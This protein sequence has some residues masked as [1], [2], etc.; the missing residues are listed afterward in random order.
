MTTKE[1]V[2]VADVQLKE[3]DKVYGDDVHAVQDLTSTSPTASSSSSSGR[4]AA[5]RRPRCA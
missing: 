5:A 3:V 1:V 2:P 4:R